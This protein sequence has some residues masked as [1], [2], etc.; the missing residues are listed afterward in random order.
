MKIVVASVNGEGR[1][2]VES[3][4]D[5]TETPPIYVWD[6]STFGDLAQTIANVAPGAASPE[7]EPAPG[8]FK[9]V[10]TVK[11]PSSDSAPPV[12]AHYDMHVTR[13]IDFDFVVKGRMNC[14]LD[15]ETV[16]LAA[17]DFIVLKA[18]NHKWVNPS[19]TEETVMLY[20]LHKPIDAEA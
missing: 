16:E 3:T 13:T 17:G 15:E 5:L 9:W 11:P 2:Y 8:H 14:I 18:A 10:F 19:D 12:G 1:S 7:I 20:L 6:E 4:R